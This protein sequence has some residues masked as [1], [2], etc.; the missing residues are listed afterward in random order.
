MNIKTQEF[1]TAAL[2]LLSLEPSVMKTGDSG[3]SGTDEGAVMDDRDTRLPLLPSTESRISQWS[4]TD[5][6]VE[7]VR[8][9]RQEKLFSSYVGTF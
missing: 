9:T 2:L 4:D 5:E 7:P 6:L 8:K 1:D 3:E